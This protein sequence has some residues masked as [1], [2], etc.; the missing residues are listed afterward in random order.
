MSLRNIFVSCFTAMLGV[1]TTGCATSPASGKDAARIASQ[2]PD[3][4]VTN[5]ETGC[6]YIPDP[7]NPDAPRPCI[8]SDYPKPT[9]K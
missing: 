2:L 3:Y 7:K 6:R 4:T 9:V 5:K 1:A 8:I